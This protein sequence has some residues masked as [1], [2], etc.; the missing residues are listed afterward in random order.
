MGI[1]KVTGIKFEKT[2]EIKVNICC[3]FYIHDLRVDEP[4]CT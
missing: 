1:L 2:A 4:V 3:Q